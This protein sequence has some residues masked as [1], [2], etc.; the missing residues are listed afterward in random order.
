MDEDLYSATV[1]VLQ[2]V[3]WEGLTLDRV[4]ERAGRARVTLWRNGITRDSLQQGLL[5]KL[6]EDYRDAMLPVVTAGGTPRERLDR[7]LHALCDVVDAHA[8]VLSLSDEMFHRAYAAGKVPL[9][10][11]APFIAALR[12]AR[13]AHLLRTEATDADL[14]DVL[15]NSA[16][17]TYL[18]FRLRHKWSPKKA[19]E[20]L[21][22][23]LL[24]G[25]LKEPSH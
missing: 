22:S 25:I 16:A 19:R 3:G 14:A 6:A 17:W 20:L 18:H 23:A 7:T 10:F 1:A 24:D 5:S 4:A 12:D 15:F 21:F 11:L 2:E 8:D 13:S 9:P